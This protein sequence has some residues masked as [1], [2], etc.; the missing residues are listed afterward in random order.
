M[1]RN[2]CVGHQ[3]PAE[4]GLGVATLYRHFGDRD[5]LIRAFMQQHA[6]KELSNGWPGRAAAISKPT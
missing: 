6:P 4:A 1:T 5:S 2:E 3:D